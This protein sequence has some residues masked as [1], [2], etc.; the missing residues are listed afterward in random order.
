MSQVSTRPNGL[1]DYDSPPLTEVVM[2]VQFSPLQNLKTTHFHPFW[3]MFKSEY[4]DVEEHPPLGP[5]FETFGGVNPSIAPNIRIDFQQTPALPRVWFVSEDKINV[6]QFQKDRL[7]HNWR[8]NQLP[9]PRYEKIKELFSRELNRAD[10]FAD[11][12]NLG[13]LKINQCELSYVN[14]IQSE[15]HEDFLKNI[16]GKIGNVFNFLNVS[17][18]TNQ[19]IEPETAQFQFTYSLKQGD[20]F[21][22]RL[23]TY[24]HPVVTSEGNEAL[25]LVLSVKGSPEGE[26]IADALVFFDFARTVIVKHFADITTEKFQKSWRRIQ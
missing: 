12:E 4:P 13:G 5:S 18:D 21:I 2:G 26:H 1:P 22:G 15:D 25:S 23:Y 20:R 6:L 7:V 19:E 24:V 8:K 14:T 10:E 11:T 17:S 16:H 9:Y 3:E